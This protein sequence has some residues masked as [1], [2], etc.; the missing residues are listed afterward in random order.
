[1]IFSARF[2]FRRL[3]DDAFRSRLSF[4]RTEIEKKCQLC[5]GSE[6]RE[7]KQLTHFL[8]FTFL[9][10][11]S[12]MN[13][14]EEKTKNKNAKT[15]FPERFPMTD[16]T[17]SGRIDTCRVHGSRFLCLSIHL[18]EICVFFAPT[19]AEGPGGMTF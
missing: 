7:K 1:M 5:I 15:S 6:R 11:S 17:D 18:V 16:T 12:E 2:F 9:G 19:G 3:R 8:L 10:D 13:S 14:M 4:C